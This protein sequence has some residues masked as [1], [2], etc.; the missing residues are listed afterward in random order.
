MRAGMNEFTVWG[1]PDTVRD[2]LYVDDQLDAILAADAVFENSLVNCNS[3]QPV[4]IGKAAEAILAALGWN[5]RIVYPAGT[6]K[7][8]SY[9]T[10][11]ATRFLQATGWK[12]RVDLVDGV[13]AVIEKDYGAATT[14]R[15]TG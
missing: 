10:I 15:A 9:K 13:R 12:P 7:G 8:T 1:R 6:F 11:D 5:A 2:L 3:N 4:T 14:G